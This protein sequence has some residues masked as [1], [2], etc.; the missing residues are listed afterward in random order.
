[1]TIDLH[2]GYQRTRFQ[3]KLAFPWKV[4]GEIYLHV[5]FLYSPLCGHIGDEFLYCPDIC[6]NIEQRAQ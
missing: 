2:S 5:V 4:H 1:M 6:N 3:C